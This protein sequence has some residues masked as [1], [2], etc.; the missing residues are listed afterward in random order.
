MEGVSAHG[1]PRV[2]QG[3][4]QP[5]LGN[6][7]CLDSQNGTTVR[8]WFWGWGMKKQKMAAHCHRRQRPKRGKWRYHSDREGTN[9]SGGLGLGKNSVRWSLSLAAGM[10]GRHHG[11][12]T[13]LRHVVA[14][15][16]FRGSHCHTWKHTSHGWRDRPQQG[17]RQQRECSGSCH[18]HQC[19]FSEC[20]EQ[21]TSNDNLRPHSGRP[22]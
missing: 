11:T 8:R 16:P 6:E 13:L 15:F 1:A 10:T 22:L 3:R 19:T 12:S 7:G 20:Y 17:D 18:S 2:Q 9:R 5:H 14:A 4:A 21:L